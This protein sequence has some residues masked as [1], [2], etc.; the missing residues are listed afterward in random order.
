MH[1]TNE[2]N[3][4]LKKH[5]YLVTETHI[6][7]WFVDYMQKIT[8]PFGKYKGK[9]LYD[10]YQKDLQYIVWLIKKTQQ[11]FIVDKMKPQFIHAYKLYKEQQEYN[12]WLCYE[13]LSSIG[14]TEF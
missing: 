10:V 12:D 3:E 14:D 4:A 9:T 13:A 1:I 11:T 6:N 7:E 2:L 8:L 5:P